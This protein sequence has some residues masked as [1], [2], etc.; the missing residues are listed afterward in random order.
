MI[1]EIT[2]TTTRAED[3]AA[4]YNSAQAVYA[5]AHGPEFKRSAARARHAALLAAYQAKWGE[6][7]PGRSGGGAGQRVQFPWQPYPTTVPSVT[8]RD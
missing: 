7:L 5:S 8:L 1:T 4:V 3:D 6:N 2:P